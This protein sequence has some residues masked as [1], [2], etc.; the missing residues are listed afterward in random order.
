MTIVLDE[1]V[2]AAGPGHRDVR[3]PGGRWRVTATVLDSAKVPLPPFSLAPLGAPGATLAPQWS[4]T[5]VEVEVDVP[6][7]SLRLSWGWPHKTRFVVE[8]L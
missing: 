3:G 5:P 7:G 4:G 6:E 1:V 2:D 8:A